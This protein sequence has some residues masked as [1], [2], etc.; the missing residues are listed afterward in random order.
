L[1][2]VLARL[3]RECAAAG[4]SEQF[5]NLRDHL[6]AGRAA[7]HADLGA[8]L[9][10][11]PGAIK[12]AIHRLRRRFRELVKAEIAHTVHDPSDQERELRDLISAL[13]R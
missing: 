12:V 3:E 11:T 7:P 13:G 6:M 8:Q 5:L 10:M 1:E 4:K 9:K 2:E